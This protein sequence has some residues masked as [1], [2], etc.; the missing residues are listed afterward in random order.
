MPP[1]GRT[2]LPPDGGW[3]P[4]TYYVVDVAYRATNPVHRAVFYSGFLHNGHPS[5]YNSV[6]CATYEVGDVYSINECY[7]LKAVSEID[8]L[9]C[10]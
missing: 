2:I 3:K 1:K 8:G 4:R 10:N 7:Y 6:W 9:S 5:G